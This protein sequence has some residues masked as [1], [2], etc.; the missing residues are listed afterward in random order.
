MAT[1]SPSELRPGPFVRPAAPWRSRSLSTAS[2]SA[3]PHPFG[4]LRP[5]WRR[6]RPYARY[7]DPHEPDSVPAPEWRE[8]SEP[9]LRV[10]RP[11]G[12]SPGQSPGQAGLRPTSATPPAEPDAVPHDAAARQ[13]SAHQ[14]QAPQPATHPA[15]TQ[16]AAVSLAERAR[17]AIRVR[18]YSSRTEK[19]YLGWIHRY[20]EF[21]RFRDPTKMGASD[22][23]R[24]LESLASQEHV[25]AAT[26]N[27]A[28]S[29]LIFLY[30]EVLDI[31]LT[32]LEDVPRAKRP[33][34]V[35]LVLTPAEVQAVLKQTRG[36]PHLV[37]QIL[38]GSGLRLLECCRLRVKDVDFTR[39][40]LTVCD[41]KGRKDRITMLPVRLQGPLRAQLERVERLHASDLALGRGSV[42]LPDALE[43]KYPNAGRE[44][45]WQWVFPAYRTY[46]DS[47]DGTIRR[48]HVHESFVQ[49]E[50]ASAV[51]AAG[52]TKP[53]TCHT[54]RH[55]FATHLLESGYDIRTIQ[56]LLGHSDVSTTM[57]Y[58]HVL[59]R[60]PH[61]VRSPLD[62]TP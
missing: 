51:R 12:Q 47:A 48:H 52:L 29:A 57:V 9:F 38:Y 45:A 17:R 23:A 21:H 24:F 60:G 6:G 8:P 28:F 3:A 37:A 49:R 55:S 39:G 27:Q 58:T 15:A 62:T 46:T 14:R 19:A 5:G 44:L 61:G 36:T 2:G 22:V 25:A 1:R 16:P 59:N 7:P 34:R 20:L 42:A 41:G 10:G 13:P 40:Q 30:R 11:P 54:L 33:L 35:P 53:A 26:Q 50:F 4:P 31:E 56:E 18:H 43:R 32:G